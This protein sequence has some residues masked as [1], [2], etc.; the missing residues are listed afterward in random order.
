[1]SEVDRE[2]EKIPDIFYVRFCDD[3]FIAHDCYETLAEAIAQLDITIKKLSLKRNV[4]KDKVAYLSLS[5]FKQ[6]DYGLPGTHA[7]N[8]LGFRITAEGLYSISKKRQKSFLTTFKKRIENINKISP[9][10]NIQERGANICKA[11]NKAF[12]DEDISDSR[13]LPLLKQS[14]DKKNLRHL[15]YIIAL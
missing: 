14:N 9:T 7:I 8:Y 6:L 3:I 10:Q 4:I 12:M 15:E 2:I 11:L 13:V 5:G 1:M